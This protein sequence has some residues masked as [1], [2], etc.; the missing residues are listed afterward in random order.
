MLDGTFTHKPRHSKENNPKLWYDLDVTFKKFGYENGFSDFVKDGFL[1]TLKSIVFIELSKEKVKLVDIKPK[2]KYGNFLKG[3][4]IKN[5]TGITI[6]KVHSSWNVKSI[7]VGEF[8]VRGHF[9]LQRCGV[10][11]SDVK[12]IYIDEFV[13]TQYIR[14]STKEL[15]LG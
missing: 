12:L 5:Q 7:S 14:K 15:V 1:Y 8:K 10:G 3:T 2:Q 6:T 13:K 11:Y 9:R 4:E